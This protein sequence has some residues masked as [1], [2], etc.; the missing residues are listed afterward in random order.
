MIEND[1]D[2]SL[3]IF[4]DLNLRS[5]LHQNFKYEDAIAIFNL[6]KKCFDKLLCNYKLSN[7]TMDFDINNLYFPQ[8][9]LIYKENSFILAVVTPF[10]DYTAI[11]IRR[12]QNEYTH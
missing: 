11:E 7:K 1:L 6:A 12:K 3:F 4:G 2:T 10:E 8:Y 5:K 9:K